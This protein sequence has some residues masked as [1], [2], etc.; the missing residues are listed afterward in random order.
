VRPEQ[1]ARIYREHF[2]FVWRSLRRLG[3]PEADALDATQDVF[4][5]VHRKLDDFE[6]R[7]K[8]T[9]WLYGICFRVAAHRR[10]SASTAH[11]SLDDILL[12]DLPSAL[13]VN[14]VIEARHARHIMDTIL[15]EMPLE[16]RAVFCAFELDG[17]SGEETAEL[18][19]ISVGTVRS[20]L[21]L[22]RERVQRAVRQ[23]QARE[24]FVLGEMG[25]E[26]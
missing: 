23:I 11:E 10:R 25:F 13:D 7:S 16:Q 14:G 3:V 24:G 26:A 21:R 22:A 12:E 4:V 15:D 20:R 8:M 9:T 19:G 2:R 18:L 1:L 6:G 5:V 17:L